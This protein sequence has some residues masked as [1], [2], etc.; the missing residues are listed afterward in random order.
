MP[1]FWYQHAEFDKLVRI[2]KALDKFPQIGR[3]Y[4]FKDERDYERKSS[5]PNYS[6][7]RLIEQVMVFQPDMVEQQQE[8]RYPFESPDSV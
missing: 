3:S 2:G 7:S 5:I 8:G 6:S 4:V 1:Q